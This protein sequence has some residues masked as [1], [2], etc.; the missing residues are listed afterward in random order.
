VLPEHEA[1]I[2]SEQIESVSL[3]HRHNPGRMVVVFY[4]KGSKVPP[5][6]Y[7]DY[8]YCIAKVRYTSDETTKWT[9]IV[10]HNG[11]L[12]SFERNVPLKN[13]KITTVN[14]IVLHPV[15]HRAVT[16]DIDHEEHER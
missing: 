10:L 3:V 4:P 15:G 16:D 7:M 12:M 1:R 11:R 9:Y 5:L 2:F 6:P 8:E 13:T 14:K